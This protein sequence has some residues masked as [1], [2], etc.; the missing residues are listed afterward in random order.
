MAT[1][2]SAVM[3]Q[4]SSSSSSASSSTGLRANSERRGRARNRCRKGDRATS[5]SPARVR[6]RILGRSALPIRSSAGSRCVCRASVSAAVSSAGACRRLGV[7]GAASSSA[8]FFFQNFSIAGGIGENRARMLTPRMLAGSLGQSAS[9]AGSGR[10]PRRDDEARS[11]VQRGTTGPPGKLRIIA[12]SLRGS[13]IAVPDRPGTAADAG[14]RARNAV[15]LARAGH[16]RRALPRSLRRH[17]RA[18]H[19]GDLAR[20]GG[21]HVRRERSRARARS[22]PRTSRGSRSKT[23]ASSTSDALGLLAGTAQPFDI[24]FLDPPFGA[25][26]LERVRAPARKRRLARGERLDLR[27]IARRRRR[28]RCRRR[29]CCTARARPAPCAIALYRRAAADP[30]S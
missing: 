4:V 11:S 3:R 15:Q 7:G 2:T 12:G 1:P 25:A 26:T 29:G 20:R 6:R 28:S 24:V 30:L 16:R 18:R 9:R 8:G 21:V 17:R 13:R 10:R 19:R 22:S 27:R 5:A 14:S 23:R